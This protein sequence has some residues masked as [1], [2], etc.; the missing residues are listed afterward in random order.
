MNRAQFQDLLDR[1][2]SD[3]RR[4]PQASLLAAESL[5]ASDGQA[6]EA[7]AQARNL[8]R[9]IELRL[10]TAVDPD[11]A[12]EAASRIAAKLSGSLPRQERGARVALAG[13]PAGPGRR[14]SAFWPQAAALSLAAALGIAMGI[15]G[16]ERQAMVDEQRVVSA[17]VDEADTGLS[18]FVAD[19]DPLMGAPL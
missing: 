11:K 12:G 5:L 2:G 6:A 13:A 19:P 10:G 1:W 18:A 17:A 3:L 16:A 15:F 9:L 4:W 14:P 8:D 7:L